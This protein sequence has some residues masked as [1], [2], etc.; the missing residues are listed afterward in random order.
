M[1]YSTR[2]AVELVQNVGLDLEDLERTSTEEN[3]VGSGEEFV[4]LPVDL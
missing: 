1:H 2:E 4:P 3:M